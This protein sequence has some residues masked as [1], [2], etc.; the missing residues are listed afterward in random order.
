MQEPG[1]SGDIREFCTRNYGVSFQMMGKVKVKGDDQH[2]VLC[3]V[4]AKSAQRL[5]RPQGA[6]EFLQVLGQ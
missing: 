5:R 3:M 6:L 2:P 4:D 1:S